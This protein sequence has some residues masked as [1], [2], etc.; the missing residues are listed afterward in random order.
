M[1]PSIEEVQLS[2]I[3]SI[4]LVLLTKLEGVWFD[5]VL[6]KFKETQMQKSQ[7]L[8]KLHIHFAKTT[9]KEE[10]INGDSINVKI[11]QKI[12]YL[13]AYLYT[14]NEEMKQGLDSVFA[15]FSLNTNEILLGALGYA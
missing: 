4:F 2:S 12:D 14:E 13:L 1:K 3:L 9:E 8:V 5:R 7:H 15:K 10:I 6:F 11:I